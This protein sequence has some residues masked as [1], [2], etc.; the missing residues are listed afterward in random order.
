MYILIQS[1]VKYIVIHCS[2]D[3]VGI[4]DWIFMS[5][6]IWHMWGITIFG[7]SRLI[8]GHAYMSSVRS[9]I[10]KLSLTFKQR[11]THC[12]VIEDYNLLK[13]SLWYKMV[14]IDRSVGETFYMKHN[15]SSS[16]TKESQNIMK[17]LKNR[18]LL[19]VVSRLNKW[20]YERFHNNDPLFKS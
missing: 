19:I 10:S 11:V 14:F 5:L 8:N 2:V 7:S 20:L 18:F 3:P 4:V 13:T 1:R 16:S 12:C 15:A 6:R 9:F 17:I